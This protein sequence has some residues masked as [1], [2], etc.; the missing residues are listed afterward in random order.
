MSA[1]LM[2]FFIFALT[3]AFFLA[4]SLS[5]KLVDPEPAI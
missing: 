2:S 3:S 4:A 5:A 1:M